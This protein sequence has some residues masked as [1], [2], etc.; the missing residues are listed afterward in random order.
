MNDAV[1]DAWQAMNGQGTPFYV[2][3]VNCNDTGVL[4]MH[5]RLTSSDYADSSNYAEHGV[6][7][8]GLSG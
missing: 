1:N 8:H 4:L 5:F 6:V 7:M 2:G 3:E